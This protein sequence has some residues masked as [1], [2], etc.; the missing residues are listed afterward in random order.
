MLNREE[1]N[2]RKYKEGNIETRFCKECNKDTEHMISKGH[3]GWD[4]WFDVSCL[5]CE[6]FDNSEVIEK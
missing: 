1:F 2:D 5:E 6:E 3:N 4:S